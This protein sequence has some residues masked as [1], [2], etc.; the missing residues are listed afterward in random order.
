MFSQR[1]PKAQCC[2]G[3]GEDARYLSDRCYCGMC[4]ADGSGVGLLCVWL[5]G[6]LLG[7]LISGGAG[8]VQALLGSS[9]S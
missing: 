1:S 8:T 5:A 7:F 2:H 4:E 9:A 6:S 3:K